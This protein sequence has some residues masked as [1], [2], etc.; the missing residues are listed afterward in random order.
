MFV[1]FLFNSLLFSDLSSVLTVA[2]YYVIGR[3][4]YFPF[5]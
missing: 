1:F 5:E 2:I 4:Q 3:R